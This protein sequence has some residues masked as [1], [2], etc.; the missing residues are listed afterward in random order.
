MLT[1]A[2]EHTLLG[3]LRDVA[4]AETS[5]ELRRDVGGRL[6]R[7]LGADYLASYVWS[8]RGE[9]FGSRVALN[10]SDANLTRYE[11]YFQFHDPIT[12]RLQVYRRATC[13][14]EV[15]S[16]RDLMRTEF[17]T[18]F[19]SVDGLHHGL[20]YFAWSGQH[21]LGDLRLWRQRRHGPFGES[22]RR[23]LDAVGAALTSALTR[24][25]VPN[26]GPQP[27]AAWAALTDRERQV[28]RAVARGM[29][30]RE[31]GETLFMSYGTV[32]AHLQHIYDKLAVRN[33]T[34][35]SRLLLQ[36]APDP[37]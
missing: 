31:V 28:A 21:N 37:A 6:M 22:E 29:T 35:L 32:R 24:M 11:Q 20:N 18:D 30:D 14:E 13:V 27:S 10:M 5:V 12:H 3:L 9:C 16:E 23:V 34:E 33:R 36:R 1:D 25:A 8:P 4:A 15:M 2:Q 17:Y 26:A 19:L 7:L